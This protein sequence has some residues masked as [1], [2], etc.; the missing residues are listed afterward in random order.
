MKSIPNLQQH[1]SF[2]L[3]S[4]V[5]R[6]EC[7]EHGAKTIEVPWAGPNLFE[8]F[9]I[10]VILASKNLKEAAGL[11]CLSWDQCPSFYN[12]T[13]FQIYLGLSGVDVKGVAEDQDVLPGKDVS[14]KVV[15]LFI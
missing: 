11:L 7:S 13:T 3:K 12:F 10:D 5:P 2:L 1:Y 8:R 9:A 6:S 14:D 15:P 4:R